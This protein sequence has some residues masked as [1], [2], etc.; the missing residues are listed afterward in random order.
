M[1]PGHQSAPTQAV[2]GRTAL[3]I[4]KHLFELRSGDL[5][6]GLELVLS[7]GYRVEIAA[8]HENPLESFERLG[9]A[10]LGEVFLRSMEGKCDFKEAF[11]AVN[12]E[13]T[14]LVDNLDY[15]GVRTALQA[16]IFAQFI[17]AYNDVGKGLS[18]KPQRKPRTS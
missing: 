7:T 15:S 8:G 10:I 14:A 11:G 3:P 18:N 9:S 16:A 13:I 17:K 5:A 12:E 1:N 4:T 2:S 6:E